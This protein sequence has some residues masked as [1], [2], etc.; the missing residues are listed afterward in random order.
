M[1]AQLLATNPRDDHYLDMIRTAV[2][3]TQPKHLFAAVAYA[4]H[5]GVAE[6]DQ[7]I[8]SM[9]PW[10][11]ARK[12]WL[13]GIDYCRSDPD[14]LAHLNAPSTSN[15]RVFD[16]E[17]VAQRAGC[18]PRNSYHPKAYLLQGQEQSA[19]IVGSGN[20][21]R[22]GLRLGIEAAV[23]LSAS[24]V[25]P[26]NNMFDWFQSNW[27]NATPLSEIAEQYQ[28][29]CASVQNRRHPVVSDDDVVPQ[30]ALARGGQL[31]PAELRKIRVCRHLWI[32]AGNLHLN[33]GRGR[34]GNQL[35]MKRNTRV[36]F[37]F[38][39]LDLEPNSYIGDIAIQ[40]AGKLRPTCQMRFSDNSMDVLT[41]PVPGEEGP[42]AYDRQV[43]HFRRVGIRTFELSVGRPVD[44]SKWKRRS[45]K[46]QGRYK[47]KSGRQWGVY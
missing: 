28:A 32:E 4:T 25:G 5:S 40:F 19:L 29:Q 34:P 2:E 44:F 16:G 35:M 9:G 17:F 3:T 8:G 36:F 1:E 33:R 6:L 27:A 38:A 11:E 47:M 30:S 46:I 24:I 12:Q 20:L 15:V 14:A 23:R 37:G 21:S 41:L 7:A 22:T 43:L 26:F 10:Q 42:D 39:A 45:A 18:V 31:R 13:V